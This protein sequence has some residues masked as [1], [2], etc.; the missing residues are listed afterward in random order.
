MWILMKYEA[1]LLLFIV[2]RRRIGWKKWCEK[3]TRETPHF[4]VI[5]HM[6]YLGKYGSVHECGKREVRNWGIRK[7]NK[8][9]PCS[10]HPTLFFLF[11]PIRMPAENYRLVAFDLFSILEKGGPKKIFLHKSN[12]LSERKINIISNQLQNKKYNFSK[13]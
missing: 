13:N 11:F 2:A 4:N 5:Y 8:F 6:N 7:S 9:L 12:F 10:P 3:P 1:N